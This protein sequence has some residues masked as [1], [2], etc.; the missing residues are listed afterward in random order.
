M[1]ESYKIS[2]HYAVGIAYEVNP[3]GYALVRR[4]PK[5]VCM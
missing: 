4:R 5:Y 3:P 2:M 1:D